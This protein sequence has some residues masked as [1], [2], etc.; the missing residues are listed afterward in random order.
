MFLLIYVYILLNH[1]YRFVNLLI[2]SSFRSFEHFTVCPYILLPHSLLHILF[3][4]L[5]HSCLRMLLLIYLYF[6]LTYIEPFVICLY[7]L[8]F[9]HLRI[10]PSARIFFYLSLSSVF[11]F[12]LTYYYYVFLLWYLSFDPNILLCSHPP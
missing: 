6:L 4:C 2:Y 10:L 7:I 12:T 8:N 9:V 11:L 3:L 1:I 5:D